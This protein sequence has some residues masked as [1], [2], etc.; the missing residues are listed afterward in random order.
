MANMSYCRFSN[1]LADLH[2]AHQN[3]DLP[4]TSEAERIA[5]QKL[6]DLCARIASDY[7]SDDE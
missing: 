3:M 4:T 6:I 5:R 7:G 1:T 2:D